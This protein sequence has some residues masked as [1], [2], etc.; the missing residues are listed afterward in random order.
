[1]AYTVFKHA[2]IVGADDVGKGDNVNAAGGLQVARICPG[3]M[4]LLLR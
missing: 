3:E 1:M 2:S 4:L